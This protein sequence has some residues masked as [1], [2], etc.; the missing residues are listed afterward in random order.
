MSGIVDRA[1]VVG[2]Q[3]EHREAALR[4]HGLQ[5]V[6]QLVAGMVGGERDGG[7]GHARLFRGR[8]QES[9]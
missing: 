2:A 4:E 3:V 6:L 7:L 1:A 5:R 8:D 9:A